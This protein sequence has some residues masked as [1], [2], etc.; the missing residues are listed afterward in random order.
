MKCQNQGFHCLWLKR[1]LRHRK[2]RAR[3]WKPT[4][5]PSSQRL[6]E[7]S[8]FRSRLFTAQNVRRCRHVGVQ[9][10]CDRGV[11]MSPRCFVS[12]FSVKYRFSSSVQS[13]I[14]G[15]IQAYIVDEGCFVL[16]RACHGLM[17][18]RSR[19]ILQRFHDHHSGSL[20]IFLN[21]SMGACQNL[22]LTS[23]SM[24]N[25]VS[26]GMTTILLVRCDACVAARTPHSC[27][28]AF[29]MLWPRRRVV[30]AWLWHHSNKLSAFVS[31]G[32]SSDFLQMCRTR[33]QNRKRGRAPRAWE[34]LQSRALRSMWILQRPE[35]TRRCALLDGH[36]G[37]FL[38]ISAQNSS[39]LSL[40]KVVRQRKRER[41]MRE[42]MRNFMK[43]FVRDAKTCARRK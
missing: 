19:R 35:Q 1:R 22:A 9:G 25:H 27:L 28:R 7:E 38:A 34:S 32:G 10:C 5:G 41:M 42:D 8:W 17:Q 3:R 29:T 16:F 11:R 14:F 30:A 13:S 15:C 40:Y 24:R 37:I 33:K 20:S 36:A 6:L 2:V 18:P 31:T 26:W 23:P 12:C 4:T 43:P 39:A 21:L